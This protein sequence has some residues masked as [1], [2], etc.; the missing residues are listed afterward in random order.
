VVCDVGACGCGFG[1]GGRCGCG[2]GGACDCYGDG[3]AY[4]CGGL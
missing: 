2:N 1:D 4:V 3:G